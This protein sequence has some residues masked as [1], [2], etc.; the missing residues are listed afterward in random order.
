MNT[1]RS[2]VKHTIKQG[3]IQLTLLLTEQILAIV[4]TKCIKHSALCPRSVMLTP[5]WQ[6]IVV[7]TESQAK[8]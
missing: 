2:K 7:A 5:H 3:T 8:K 4:T 6:V 1:R